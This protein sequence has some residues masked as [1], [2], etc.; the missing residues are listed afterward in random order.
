MEGVMRMY[1]GSVEL[2][3]ARPIE[4]DLSLRALVGCANIVL[5]FYFMGAEADTFAHQLLAGAV[6]VLLFLA[7]VLVLR[8]R[9]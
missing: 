6:G 3:E 7:G 9:P 2:D 4:P 1:K 5:G 8:R